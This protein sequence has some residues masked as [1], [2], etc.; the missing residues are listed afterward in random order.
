MDNL[1]KIIKFI[2]RKVIGPILKIKRL[3]YRIFFKLSR[4]L[5]KRKSD[6]LLSRLNLSRDYFF[7]KDFENLS[8]KDSTLFL[9]HM[10]LPYDTA[11]YSTRTHSIL[12]N[13]KE[14]DVDAY[15][16]LGYPFDLIKSRN[17]YESIHNDSKYLIHHVSYDGVIYNKLLNK[18]Y[19]QDKLDRY[20]YIIEYSNSI[21]ELVKSKRYS[22][23]H[24]NSD[25]RNGIAAAIASIVT[26]TPFIYEVRGLWHV[27]KASKNSEYRDTKDYKLIERLEVMACEQA[28]VVIA[29]TLGI[30]NWLIDRGID[31]TKIQVVPNGVDTNSFSLSKSSN[32]NKV[33]CIGYIGS[34]V[35]Y[36]GLELLIDAAKIMKDK[37]HN[38]KILLVGDGESFSKIKEKVK[39]N[40]LES[41]VE[42]TGRVPFDKVDTFYNKID[43]FVYPRLPVEVCELVSPLKPFEAMFKKKAI[44]AS[45]VA[46]QSEFIEEGYNGLL[47]RKGDVNSIV[48]KLEQ[49]ISSSEFRST[50]GDNAHHWVINNRK[51]PEMAKQIESIYRDVRVI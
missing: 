47:H 3:A 1:L 9:A 39:Q 14:Y 7:S 48:D 41:E 27:T 36:E 40:L 30:K 37:G 38:F 12:R 23:I 46:A 15:T 25:Y 19:G 11:G 45:D 51:W 21:I 8:R 4:T 49:L 34:F 10:S 18:N 2:L 33:V 42:L 6:R 43:I 17:K 5:S 29:L 28:T 24:A 50:L 20:S 44:V 16:R 26:D 22:V 32:D 35:A 31:E 13:L